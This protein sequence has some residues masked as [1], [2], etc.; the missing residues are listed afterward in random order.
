MTEQVRLRA[1]PRALLKPYISLLEEITLAVES[2]PALNR[3]TL[4]GAAALIGAATTASASTLATSAA[5]R[6]RDAAREG[7]TRGVGPLQVSPIGLGCMNMAPNFYNP[8]PDPK[9]M[10][11][12]IRAAHDMGCTFFDTAEVY[13]PHV[14]ET[15][16]G[17]A[18]KPIRNQVVLASKFGFQIDGSPQARNRNAHPEHLREALDGML[19]RLQ[20]GYIDL[21]YLHRVD[22][23]VPIE[24]VAGTVRDLIA[25]GKVRAFGLS[26]A[27]PATV[28]RAHAVQPVA[29]LQNE[30]SLIERVP[31]VNALDVCE[32]LGIALVAW[33]PTARALLADRYN[34]YSRF[35]PEDR[36]ASVA[37]FAPDALVANME[38]VRLTRRWADAKG[39]TPVQFALAWI[40]AQKPFVV[41]IPGTTK[42]HHMRENWGA[43]D[44]ALTSAD[45]ARFRAELEAIPVIGARRPNTAMRD[46]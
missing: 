13:G 25:Q 40:L 39:V 32:E 4:L 31:E 5:P 21:L 9:E 14:S 19:K 18:L 41:A 36:H 29:A 37:Y 7:T 1:P 15:I 16:V 26:E 8:A 17:E 23:K 38:V 42:I 45:L 22:P 35:A 20:T 12:V 6:A 44:V 46:V 24:D 33:S 27:A 28:R 43:L 11:K 3:R 10:V 34:E 30:Y 2:T